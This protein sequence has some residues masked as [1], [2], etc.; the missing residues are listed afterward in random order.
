MK[1]LDRGHSSS[2]SLAG[3]SDISIHNMTVVRTD[4][5]Y[6]SRRAY[7]IPVFMRTVAVHVG[8]ILLLTHLVTDYIR[9]YLAGNDFNIPIAITHNHSLD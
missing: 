8:K 9:S 7:Q 6:K 5:E 3:H 1:Y 2:K 4:R